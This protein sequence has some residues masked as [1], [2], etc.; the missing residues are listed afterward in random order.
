MQRVCMDNI[1]VNGM[2]IF[3]YKLFDRGLR[4]KPGSKVQLEFQL[5]PSH[6]NMLVKGTIVYINSIDRHSTTI[7]VR[8][9]P[10]AR[11]SRLLNEYIAPRKQEI[12]EELN[13][14]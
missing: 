2:G 10:T 8:L 5:S 6:K 14:A 12:L 9:F 3:A 13:Q 4:I 1:S 7:G 11:K